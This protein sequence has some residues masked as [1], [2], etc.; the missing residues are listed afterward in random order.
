MNGNVGWQETVFLHQG[1]LADLFGQRHSR[2]QAVHLR[3]DGQGG[4][5]VGG[6]GR[7]GRWPRRAYCVVG[8]WRGRTAAVTKKRA[9][10]QKGRQSRQGEFILTQVCEQT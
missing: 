2:Q 8:R 1:H 5:E 6:W 7:N 10:S 4:V 9:I 3:G